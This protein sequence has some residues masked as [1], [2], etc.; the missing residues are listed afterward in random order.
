MSIFDRW[1]IKCLLVYFGPWALQN[2][3]HFWSVEFCLTL[4]VSLVIGIL[5]STKLFD[6]FSVAGQA[7]VFFRSSA[8]GF[9]SLW[10]WKSMRRRKIKDAFLRN[11]GPLINWNH[12][13]VL[14]MTNAPPK[15][16]NWVYLDYSSPSKIKQV[17]WTNDD[18]T[19]SWLSIPT[20]VWIMHRFSKPL[21]YPQQIISL[22]QWPCRRTWIIHVK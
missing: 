13:R 20:I 6:L 8:F 1:L 9:A 19:V 12:F 14:S 2:I 16:H 10:C 5:Y 3:M 15:G 18:N 4:S 17:K 7:L 21:D 22:H 11:Y